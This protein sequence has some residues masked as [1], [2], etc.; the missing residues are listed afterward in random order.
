MKNGLFSRLQFV[1]IILSLIGVAAIGQIIHIQNSEL[2]QEVPG[3]GDNRYEYI[4]RVIEPERGKIYDRW[5][6]LLVGNEEVYEIG[7]DRKA[8]EEARNLDQVSSFLAQYLDLTKEEI[9]QMYA[10]QSEVIY[11]ILDDF[12]PA[13]QI[14]PIKTE[15]AR[16]R[17]YDD[18]APAQ[19]NMS[20]VYLNAH[21][22][23]AYPEGD[24]ASNILGF[25]NYYDRLEGGPHLGVEE[26]YDYLLRGRAIEE[27][28]AVDP[29][30]VVETED[31]APTTDLILTLDRD[32]QA[33]VEA[34]LEKA[35]VETE[36][37]SGTAI[38]LVPKTGEILA[39]ATTPRM[40]PNLY[41]KYEEE[42]FNRAIDR[43]YEPGSVFKIITMAAALDT[44]TV[45]ADTTY[46]DLGSIVIGGGTPIHNWDNNAYGE[47]TM[48][49]CLEHSLNVCLAWVADE[50]GAD[51]FYN[52][53]LRFGFGERT[54]I[55]LAGEI[56]WPLNLPGGSWVPADLGQNSFGQGIGVTPVQMAVALSAVANDGIIMAPHIVHARV[57]NGYQSLTDPVEIGR[58]I[59]EET[60]KTLS[61]MLTQSLEGEAKKS[62]VEGYRV[63]GKTGTADI[64][65]DEGYTTELTNASFAGWGPADD[66][67]FLVYLWLEKPKTNRWSSVVAAPVFKEIVEN[68]VVMMNI[69]PDDVR[70]ALFED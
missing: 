13:K 1:N 59:S 2:Y 22:K 17:G 41:W 56:A 21:L 51:Q 23:R 68:L 26:A 67:Q 25:Y 4:H 34:T 29:N 16:F 44:E 12:V 61:D 11:F 37:E 38:I 36:S 20:G 52:Y 45:E 28:I 7:L 5:G 48:I 18:S 57:T 35:I 47:Q 63:A 53:I 62:Y 39:M 3:I 64:A 24:L 15:I 32:I 65:S 50:T 19:Y 54:K 42:H 60:A 33:M 43:F 66:P 30:K 70:M 10:D 58:P 40:D 6:N 14:E 69:P 9:V 46:N 31:L 8:I 27:E 55:D 49:G